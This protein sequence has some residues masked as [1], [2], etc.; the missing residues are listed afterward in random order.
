MA[1]ARSGIHLPLEKA[2]DEIIFGSL[3]GITSQ[4]AKKDILTP[5]KEMDRRNKE[6]Y[7]R[8]GVVDASVRR[9]MYHRERNLSKPYLNSRDGYAPP[10]RL[11]MDGFATYVDT[12][13]DYYEGDWDSHAGGVHV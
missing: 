1:E 11:V 2:A 6:V 5:W 10:M 7:A 3:R 9:G 4:N 13:G 12:A 8:S